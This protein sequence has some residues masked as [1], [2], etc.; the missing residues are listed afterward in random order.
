MMSARRR[1]RLAAVFVGAAVAVAPLSAAHATTEEP[2]ELVVPI[3]APMLPGQQG[4]LSTLWVANK[5]VCDVKVTASGPGLT[6]S[7]PTNTAT[8]SS[9]YINS[10]LAIGNIDYTAF[11]VA[12][13]PTTAV[14]AV[15]VNVDIAYTKLPAGVITKADDLKTKKFVCTGTKATQTVTTNLPILP[16][17]GSGLVQ[18]TTAATV[19]KNKPAWVNIDF[20]GWKSNLNNFRVTLTP[21]QGLT[22]TY[23][24]DAAS[25]G[26]HEGALL[27]VGDQDH[28]AVRLDA[29]GLVPGQY[30]VPVRATYTGG[31][32]DGKLTLTVN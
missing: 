26:L 5:D 4:W 9:M 17:L 2:L 22:V 25:A 31:S 18:K 10:A 12:V 8:H 30:E 7:Y 20:Q 32:Y 11:K 6:V 23:P 3:L 29:S 27:A 19:A 16:V 1:L 24:G 28:V 14:G 21:P 13:A 15:K